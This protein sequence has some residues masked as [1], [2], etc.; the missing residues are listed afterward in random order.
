[1]SP[2]T[3]LTAVALPD[4]ARPNVGLVLVSAWHTQG[5]K[6]QRRVMS[7]VMDAWED[8]RLPDAYL[9]RHCLEG[10][11]GRTIL[12]YAQ[13]TGPGAAPGRWRPRTPSARSAAGPRA[14]VSRQ[15]VASLHTPPLPTTH[16]RAGTG[17]E[18]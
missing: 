9:S 7:G 16:A 18:H 14:M 12:N 15:L 13:W 6:D 1:M 17:L 11:D 5:P 8:T 2:D 3:E 10:S 4:P